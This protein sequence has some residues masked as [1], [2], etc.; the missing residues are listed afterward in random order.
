MQVGLNVLSLNYALRENKYTANLDQARQEAI[1]C[2]V[3]AVPTF[4]IGEKDRIV[5]AQSIDIFRQ[6]LRKY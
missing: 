2:G 3:T 4:I 1:E 6:M 5:G